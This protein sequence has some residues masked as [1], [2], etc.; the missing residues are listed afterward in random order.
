MRALRTFIGA[1]CALAA[2]GVVP[3]V[4]ATPSAVDE[5]HIAALEEQFKLE[6]ETHKLEVAEAHA[7]EIE[8]HRREL[9]EHKHEL[10]LLRRRLMSAPN[11]LGGAHPDESSSATRGPARGE[12]AEQAPPFLLISPAQSPPP[13]QG[14]GVSA[15]G[16]SRTTAASASSLPEDLL[17]ALPA[18]PLQPFR[19]PEDILSDE[20]R[21]EPS[22]PRATGDSLAVAVGGPH[23]LGRDLVI[24]D[25]AADCDCGDSLTCTGWS[26]ASQTVGDVDWLKWLARSGY[27]GTGSTGPSGDHTT[28]SGSYY[29]TKAKGNVNG[30]FALFLTLPLSS[31]AFN[32]F[33][34]QFW[35]VP[36]PCI[37]LACISLYRRTQLF[38]LG[39]TPLWQV[40]HVWQSDWNPVCAWIY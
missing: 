18:P 5:A 22:A 32:G 31:G 21:H 40:P 34:V 27:T 33:G 24:G 35:C 28:G 25:N 9:E 11:P 17:D 15:P 10:E 2:V 4:F 13:G 8:A 26:T 36:E 12:D 16:A 29:Y 38:F 14:T 3:E 20:P 19:R 39:N 30:F 37:C 1:A 23:P 7:R 6:L